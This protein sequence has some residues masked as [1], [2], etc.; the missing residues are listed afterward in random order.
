MDWGKIQKL[1]ADAGAKV[2]DEEVTVLKLT[3]IQENLTA[4]DSGEVRENPE[5]LEAGLLGGEKL[6]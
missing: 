4:M 5:G 3:E 2:V 1:D 6:G